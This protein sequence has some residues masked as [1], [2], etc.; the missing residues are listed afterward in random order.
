MRA[1][2]RISRRRVLE[3][4]VGMAAMSLLAACG[5]QAAPA[6]PSAPSTAPTS[7][8]TA[9]ATSAPVAAATTAPPPT[10]QA[11]Q[12]TAAPTVSPSAQ[13]A[14]QAVQQ[15]PR[16]QTLIMSLSDALNQFSDP[17]LM[18]PFMPGVTRNGWQFAYEPL[19][20]YDMWYTD[21]V[22]A[23]QGIPCKDGEIPWLAESY[24]YNQDYSAL[25]IKLRTGVTWSDGQPFT[26]NDVVFTLNM[27]KDNAPKLNFS[28]EMKLWVKDVAALDDHTVTI[29]LTS[30]NPRFMFNYFQWHS[31]L[32]F[33]IVPEH[34]FKGQ[35][36]TTFTNFDLEKGWPIATGPWRL[37]LESPEQR[38]WDRRDDWWGAKTGFHPLPK[39]KRVTV[40]PNLNDDKQ[41]Q[42]LTANQVDCTH[43]FQTAYTVPTALQ[44]NP[45]LIAWTAG[46]KAPY[47]ALDISTV[48]SMSF[49]NSKPPFND[50]D[51][52]WAINHALDRKQIAEIGTHGLTSGTVLPFPPYGPLKQFYNGVQDLLQKFPIDS[53]DL[54]K[55]AQL[56]QAKGYQKDQGGFWSKGGQ[57]FSLILTSPPP[58]FT[59]IT[60][61]IIE[62]LRKAG[63]DASFKSPANSGTLISTG[64][65]DAFLGVPGGSVR[66]PYET[67]AFFLSRYSAPTGQ[68][69]VQ[70]YRW[71]NDKYDSLVDQMAKL[72]GTDPQYMTLYHQAMEIWIQALPMIPLV[73]RYIYITPNTTY[74]KNWPSE[75]YPYTL[76]SSWHRTSGLFINTLEPSGG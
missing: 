18:N 9:A 17:K 14:S 38:F 30:P 28:T 16:T 15:I 64:D 57:R 35:D 22:C 52:R 61:V 20:F 23:P 5:Q 49:N 65:V 41:I 73:L 47:G 46:N 68:T 26:A 76:P 50:P 54:N 40:I 25:T 29:T 62:Q 19:Y 72:P 51:I 21:Q 8:P 42:L 60:P 24:S 75:T 39:M 32:G 11:A 13:N 6:S 10:A 59:D 58:F 70:P 27:L 43:G 37:T 53:F 3:S 31:D 2:Y 4:V 56:M 71:K 36:P 7:A 44:Q 48:T 34:I 1:S 12:P 33:P 69:A 55:T 63:F 74:W 45:K 66:D 67:M